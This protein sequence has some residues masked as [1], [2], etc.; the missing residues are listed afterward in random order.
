MELRASAVELSTLLPSE[1]ERMYALYSASYRDT[2]YAR[3]RADL[4]DKTHCIV[5]RGADGAILGFSTLKRYVTRWQG[6]DIRV[7][8]SGDTIVDPAHWGSQQLAF[9]WIRHAGQIWR[10]APDLPLYWFLIV[11]GH[12]TYRYLSAFAREYAPRVG[13]VVA[14]TTRALMD[15]LASERYGRAYDPAT[16][17]LRFD[18]PMGRLAP[19]LAD[20][21]VAHRQLPDVDYFL[22]CNP[23]YARGDELVCLCELRASNLR[24]LARRLFDAA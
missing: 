14:D 16:G 22:Q 11:K 13:K 24:P 9:E 8:F 12:R 18:E 1:I 6:T 21:P 20:I 23:Q 10:E 4:D 15:H 7:I 19:A 17:L 5:L 3:F 2:A